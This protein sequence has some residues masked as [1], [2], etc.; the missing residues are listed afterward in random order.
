M[1]GQVYSSQMQTLEMQV[2]VLG[3]GVHSVLLIQ[4]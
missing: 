1:Q 2:L 4:F 3:Q